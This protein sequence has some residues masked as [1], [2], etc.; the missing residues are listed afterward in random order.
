MKNA[1]ADTSQMNLA[2]ASE[3][4]S[5]A[6]TAYAK[7]K[8]YTVSGKTNYLVSLIPRFITRKKTV[9]ITSSMFKDK[10]LRN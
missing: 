5:S 4:V 7:N 1:N 2:S 8:M 6:L 10:M 9:K 3:V